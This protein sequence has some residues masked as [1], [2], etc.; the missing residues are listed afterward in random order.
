[1]DLFAGH[2]GQMDLFTGNE[3]K[4]EY[5]PSPMDKARALAPKVGKVYEAPF[6]YEVER[7]LALLLAE[8]DA[9]RWVAEIEWAKEE[10]ESPEDFLNRMGF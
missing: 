6:D 8:E 7:E 4:T 5:P 3:R 10:S 9:E 1:M 2:I